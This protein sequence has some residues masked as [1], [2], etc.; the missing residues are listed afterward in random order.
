[1]SLHLYRE[2]VDLQNMGKMVWWDSDGYYHFLG[3]MW[4]WSAAQV[5]ELNEMQ[6]EQHKIRRMQKEA[7]AHRDSNVIRYAPGGLL[8]TLNKLKADKNEG[9]Q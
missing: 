8:S 3:P 6:K 7:E 2:N 5:H 9:W 1:M 4:M